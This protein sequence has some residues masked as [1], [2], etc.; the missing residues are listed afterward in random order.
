MEL[1]INLLAV[2]VAA[3]VAQAA[4]ALWYSPVLFGKPWMRIMNFSKEDMEHGKE[5]GMAKYYAGSFVAMLVTSYVLAHFVQMAGAVTA[6]GGLYLAFW[7]WLGFTAAVSVSD[8]LFSG[9]P[10]KLFLIQHG[11]TL[12]SF[13]L[14]GAILAAWQ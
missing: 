4:G 10:Q 2:L 6:S 9:R 5:K 8:Y 14:M 13:L 1:S 3:V 11:Y 12:V 7:A